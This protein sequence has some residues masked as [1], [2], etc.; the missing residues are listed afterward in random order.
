MERGGF[1]AHDSGGRD[2]P[3]RPRRRAPAAVPP[4]AAAAAGVRLRS[5]A[6]RVP[7]RVFAG[8]GALSFGGTAVALLLTEGEDASWH[9]RWQRTEVAVFDLVLAH[10]L[11]RLSRRPEGWRALLGSSVL[12]G[13]L[14]TLGHA[15][16]LARRRGG[17]RYHLLAGA[18]AALWTAVGLARWA[19]R[20]E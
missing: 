15:R 18:S 11:V 9:Q 14:L 12:V 19:D 16:E 7:L 6:A 1:A 3:P 13:G 17:G 20:S 5:L 2:R 4:R 10:D 8:A